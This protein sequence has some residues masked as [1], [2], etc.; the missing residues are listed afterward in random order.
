VNEVENNI[1]MERNALRET[2]K[3]PDVKIIGVAKP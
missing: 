1:R 2:V 3:E